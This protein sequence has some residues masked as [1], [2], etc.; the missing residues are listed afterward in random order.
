MS[1]AEEIRAATGKQMR[2]DWAHYRRM[3]QYDGFTLFGCNDENGEVDSWLQLGAEPVKRKAK[4]RKIFPGIND[5]ST[6]EY[7]YVEV[8][9]DDSGNAIKCYLLFIPDERYYELKIKPQRDRNQAIR[10]SMGMGEMD[11]DGQG[12]VMP[13]VKG[14]RTYAPNTT[15]NGESVGDGH[16]GLNTEVTHEA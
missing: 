1:K 2:L 8:G 4:S 10:Q 3:P 13:N 9:K 15:V 11:N 16:R 6:S 12:K 7:E 14:I 5:K